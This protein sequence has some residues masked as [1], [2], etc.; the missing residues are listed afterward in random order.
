MAWRTVVDF[1][2][3]HH[4]HTASA[5]RHVTARHARRHDT[6]L[7]LRRARGHNV[8]VEDRGAGTGGG[9]AGAA[10][11]G[12]GWQGRRVVMC[13]CI[14]YVLWRVGSPWERDGPRQ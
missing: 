14:L 1:P 9:E 5:A 6:R 10:T 12:R 7:P 13:G 3:R 11:G 2:R 4:D 8:S